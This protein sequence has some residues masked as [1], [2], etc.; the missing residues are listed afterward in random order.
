MT[1]IGNITN[2]NFILRHLETCSNANIL[3]DMQMESKLKL[4]KALLFQSSK[5]KRLI[6]E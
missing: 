6:Y 2:Y 1:K 5:N 4:K 3:Y